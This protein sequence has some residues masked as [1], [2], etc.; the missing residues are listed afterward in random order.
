[1]TATTK[2]YLQRL[3][4]A[5]GVL[6]IAYVLRYVFLHFFEV[7]PSAIYWPYFLSFF[8]T[9]AGLLLAAGIL[10]ESIAAAQTAIIVQGGIAFFH[11]LLA[12]T[13]GKS[14]LPPPSQV[15]VS[16]YY[17]IELLPYIFFVSR[18]TPHWKQQ[19]FWVIAAVLVLYRGIISLPGTN[20]IDSPLNGYS[21]LYEQIIVAVH[22]ISSYCAFVVLLTELVLHAGRNEKP[23]LTRFSITTDNHHGGNTMA[24]FSFKT[25][26]LTLPGLLTT[27]L[28]GPP[29]IEMQS[30]YDWVIFFMR[31]DWL[32]SILCCLAALGAGVL[33]LR[34]HIL[35]FMLRFDLKSKLIFWLLSIPLAGFIAWLLFGAM[36]QP[37]TSQSQQLVTWKTFKKDPLLSVKVAVLLA[38][39]LVAAWFFHK[40]AADM[41]FIY[42][43]AGSAGLFLLSTLNPQA[44]RAQLY[45]L[46]AIC[47]YVT[48]SQLLEQ[49]GYEYFAMRSYSGLFGF[50]NVMF[51]A[52]LA[53]L[54][55][56]WSLLLQPVL[57]PEYFHTDDENTNPEV[58]DGNV[59]AEHE[60]Q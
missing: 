21:L 24:F 1:M 53:V 10:L 19:R 45:I 40:S 29:S 32:I 42:I 17:N 6:A 18:L 57:Q 5:L 58:T 33:Y 55:M 16:F 51:I 28:A 48:G 2:T 38:Y 36:K 56:A 4:A 22:K 46:L 7:E 34:A 59:F 49:Q 39:A 50:V 30:E 43:L 15:A 60:L 9:G 37:A 12:A 3:P 52:Q 35:E 26:L 25:L 44:Y 11:F 27:L 20:V 23:A 13:V 8:V 54:G 41:D 31:L 14:A 47:A